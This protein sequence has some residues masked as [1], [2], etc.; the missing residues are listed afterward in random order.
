MR[1]KS[2]LRAGSVAVGL[3]LAAASPAAM[4]QS[5]A[6]LHPA[7][8]GI[9]IG[10]GK[11]TLVR[12]PRPVTDV[13]VVNNKVADVQIKSPT[14]L[15]LL[16]V[17]GGETSFYATDAAGRVVYSANVRVAH[18]IDQIKSMLGMTMPGAAIDVTP[19]N[20][21]V[22]LT[23][24]VS[25]PAEVE[26]AQRLTQAFAG[27]T[28][29]LN[30][31]KTAMPVQVNLQVKFAE[32]SR[33]TLKNVGVSFESIGGDSNFVIGVTRGRE[34]LNEA[35]GAFIKPGTGTG[36]AL[37]GRLLGLDIA[38]VIDALETD[39]LLSILAEPN[40]TAL[41]GE[42]ANFLAGGEFPIPVATGNGAVGIEF[43][44]YGVRLAFTPTVLDGNRISMR[45]QPE[46]SELDLANGVKLNN[47]DVP[48]LLSRRAD[49]TIELGSGQS[50]M[51]AGLL[52][53]S[54][55]TAS[56]RTPLLG[57]LPILGALF[58]S[59]SYRRNETELVI[60]ITPY[61]V[62]PVSANRIHLPTDGYRAPTDAE[63]L[64]QGKIHGGSSN[65]PKPQSHIV[66]AQP[67]TGPSPAS[68]GF[69][70]N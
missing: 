12:L 42:T 11:A 27:G 39:G 53:N 60:V 8:D 32:V 69:A 15:Y 52:R 5:E 20:G 47:F 7:Q 45:V 10:V 67:A 14:Q 21:M 49:T 34:I 41:S 48:G 38:S 58:R 46:V 44:E 51:I 13:L 68:P 70:L 31:L 19:L 29:I 54:V 17:G 23:G 43:K 59:D 61:L 2:M 55:N 9:A 4:A 62:K 50:F 40:L 35:T 66:P 37:A 18:N 57:N 1:I 64:L 25:S 28:M 63:R 26:E 3:A 22:L 24:T 65:A 33:T 30:K 6:T 36:L 56:D 16:G